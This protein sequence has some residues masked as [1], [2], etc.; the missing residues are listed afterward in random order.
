MRRKWFFGCLGVVGVVILAAAII[1]ITASQ[2][3]AAREGAE[4]QEQLRLANAEGIPTTW[5][6]FAATI[7]PAKP[8]ENAAP[9]YQ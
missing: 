5:Q 8:S 4:L 7:K 9:L 3:E 2:M 1:K 6:E